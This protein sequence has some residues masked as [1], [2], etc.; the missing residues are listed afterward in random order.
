MLRWKPNRRFAAYALILTSALLPV[1]AAAV[2]MTSTNF[3]L[4]PN[5]AGTFGGLGTSTSY[6]LTDIGGEAVVGAGA[7][8]SYKLGQGYVRQLPQSIQL[9]VLPSGTYSYWPMDTGAGT[10]VYDGS[11][12][13]N[14]GTLQNSPTWATG[15]IGEAVTLNGSSQYISTSTTQANPTAFTIEIWF[16]STSGS[17][18]RLFGFGNAATGA[19]SS[20]DRHLYLTNSGQIVFGTNPGPMKTVTTAASYNDGSWHHVAASLGSGGLLLYVDGIRQGTDL[21]TT[22]AASYTGYWRIGYD[23]LTGWPSAPTSNYLAGT[24]DEARVVTRQLSDAEVTNDYTAGA[25]ALRGAFTLPNITPGGSQTYLVDAI[26]KTDAGGY[27]LYVQ[28]PTP[29]THT[30][31][32]TTIPDISG[33]IA[34]PAAWTEG[35]TKG[36]GFTLTAGTQVEAKYGTNPN[37]NYAALPAGSTLFHTRTGLNGGVPEVTTMQ[38]RADTTTTQKQGTYTTNVI[39]TATTKP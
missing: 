17:G 19:S 20:L 13:A 31:N 15:I 3:R 34:S 39:Y 30:D 37:Y 28:R 24:V 35:T 9:T 36:F 23:D 1:S 11:M 4:D 26:V 32:V 33:N 25:A 29:L 14:D 10:R 18:G 6:K 5:T 7:S 12:T 22:T 8:Q 38:Y 21:T 27:D 2:P 16:K